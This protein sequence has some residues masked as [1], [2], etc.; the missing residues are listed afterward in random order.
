M[1]LDQVVNRLR[2]YPANLYVGAG[3]LAKRYDCSKEVIYKAKETVRAKEG[4]GTLTSVD[5]KKGI[6]ESKVD[7]DFE[8]KSL[9]ELAILHKIDLEEYNISNYWTKLKSNGKFTSSVFCTKRLVDNDLVKQKDILLEELKKGFSTNVKKLVNKPSSLAYEISIPDVHF[10]KLSWRGET[11]EDYDIQIAIDRYEAAIETLLDYAGNRNFQKIIFPIGNDM[12]NIDSRRNETFLGTAQDT[13]SRFF[14]IV[15]VVK[16]ILIRNIEKLSSIAHTDVIVIGGNHDPETMFMIGEILDSYFH[17][18]PNVTINNLPKQ[19][20]YYQ[21]G[22]NGFLYTHGNEE[23]H[24]DLGL[25]FATEE[26]R[27][28][29]DTKYR[30]VKLGHFHKNKKIEYLSVDDHHSLQVQVLPSLSG[31]DA[32]HTSKGYIS[33]KQAKSFVYDHEKGQVAEFTFT[34]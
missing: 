27:L 2:K 30:F 14:K 16:E 6:L 33:L 21:F 32:W 3:K 26:P 8:P 11:G 25:I 9:Q 12:I 17:K 28:W 18:N 34:V 29:A 19:R 13:D 20:K 1:T 31:S 5:V 24:S 15:K 7:C 4:E 23:K 22:K 10:G